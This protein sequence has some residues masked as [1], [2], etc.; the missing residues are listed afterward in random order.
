MQHQQQ[1]QQHLPKAAYAH[2]RGGEHRLISRRRAWKGGVALP[3]KDK[4]SRAETSTSL[5]QGQSARPTGRLAFLSHLY[6]RGLGACLPKVQCRWHIKQRD[7]SWRRSGAW[8]APPLVL[9]S[10]LGFF[11][12]PLLQSSAVA[13]SPPAVTSRS[14]PAVMVCLFLCLVLGVEWDGIATVK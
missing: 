14:P 7:E 5:V 11:C 6:S 10:F 2:G 1:Q 8:L 13:T 3:Q 4:P 12:C 9:V